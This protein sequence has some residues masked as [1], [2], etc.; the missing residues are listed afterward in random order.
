MQVVWEG[1]QV[2]MVSMVDSPLLP[3]F[4]LFIAP[5]IRFSSTCFG[6]STV[7]TLIATADAEMCTLDS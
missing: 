6:H 1:E 4:S 3:H 2:R 5:L 7:R